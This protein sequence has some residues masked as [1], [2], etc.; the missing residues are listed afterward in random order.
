V[1]TVVDVDAARRAPAAGKLTCPRPDC[2][3]ILRVRSAGPTPAGPRPG[4]HGG[5]P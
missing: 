4:R 1:I 5:H 2:A 3:G